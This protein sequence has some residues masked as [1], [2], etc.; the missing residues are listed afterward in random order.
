MVQGKIF[1]NNAP[2]LPA[3]CAVCNNDFKPNGPRAIDF[4]TDLDYYGAILICELCMTNAAELIELV[5]VARYN[6][7]EGNLNVAA[8]L[9]VIANRK[10][11]ILE[12][13]VA[14]YFSDPDFSIDSLLSA[15]PDLSILEE[16]A[17]ASNPIGPSRESDESGFTESSPV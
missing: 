11:R 4:G 10:N 15:H 6:E 8:E 13:F 1:I 16:L 9:L 17:G 14:A 7:V 12:S 5:P 2:P 3:K